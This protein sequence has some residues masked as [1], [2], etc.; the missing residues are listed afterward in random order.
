MPVVYRCK[1][2]GHRIFVFG[3]VGQDCKGI[4]TPQEVIQEFGPTCPACGRA[5]EIPTAG[6]IAV[7]P[8]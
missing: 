4:R 2:C 5:L 7:K 6:R 8:R 1:N 3:R